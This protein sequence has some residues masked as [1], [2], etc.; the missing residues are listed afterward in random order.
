[1]AAFWYIPLYSLQWKCSGL[2]TGEYGLREGEVNTDRFSEGLWI[3]YIALQFWW[4]LNSSC[5]LNKLQFVLKRTAYKY[6]VCYIFF[7]KQL[8]I[9]SQGLPNLLMNPQNCDAPHSLE[10]PK[11]FM[12][13]LSKSDL[14]FQVYTS[15][16][17]LHPVAIPHW[18]KM[19]LHENQPCNSPFSGRRPRCMPQWPGD[20]VL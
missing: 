1:M 8:H 12:E 5:Y 11:C 4:D 3:N 6:Y 19:R 17:S 18:R 15:Q 16:S 10:N 13:Y 14:N 9:A 7:S 2:S 20:H